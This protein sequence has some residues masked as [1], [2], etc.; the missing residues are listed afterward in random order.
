MVQPRI[1]LCSW[2]TLVGG[3]VVAAAATLLIVL[4]LRAGFSPNAPLPAMDFT[5]SEVADPATDSTQDR[6]APS[7]PDDGNTPPNHFSR[8]VEA[9]QTPQVPVRESHLVIPVLGVDAAIA[10]LPLDD[11]RS[12]VLPGDVNRITLWD[13]SA[14]ITGDTGTILV[15]GHVD[16]ASQGAGALYWI[17]TLQPGDAVFLA[18]EGV[19]TRW[20]VTGME[21]VRKA[22]L[23]E[24]IWA[25][26]SGPRQLVL[27]TCGGELVRDESGRGNYLDNV[28][29]TA[30]PF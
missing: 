24:R 29:V 13:G 28:V 19:V 17:H 8:S 30:T 20:K 25:G 1:S 3:V 15:A 11:D 18:R 22:A 21:T 6:S 12:L 7:G 26:D 23:P 5:V 27:V 10:E 2:T 16:N 9:G 14:A 4:G